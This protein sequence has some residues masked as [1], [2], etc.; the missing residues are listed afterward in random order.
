MQNLV[1]KLDALAGIETENKFA[2][3]LERIAFVFLILTFICAPHSIAATQIAWITG[4]FAWFVRLFI[5]PRLKLV[6]TPLDYPLWAL[7]G[8]SVIS[9]IFSYAPDISIDKL[10]VVALFLIFYFVINNLR[11]KRAAIFLA[12]ALIFS[13]MVNVVWTPIQR[14]IGRGVEIHEIKDDSPLKIIGLTNGDALIEADSKRISSPEEIIEKFTDKEIVKI[15]F[16]RPDFYQ[17]IE[18]KRA[19]LLSGNTGGGKTRFCRL[20]Q[21]S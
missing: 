11:T 6:R 21:K 3:F 4:M 15:G 7:F 16:Y 10:R 8:W 9:A 19:D 18:L 20:E 13:C 12:F 14:A 2:R 5:K 17:T 1:G